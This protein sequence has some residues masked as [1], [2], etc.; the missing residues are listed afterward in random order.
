MLRVVACVARWI[1]AV[2]ALQARVKALVEVGA[3]L[4]EKNHLPLVNLIDL[5]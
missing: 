5:A 2:R 3:W 4:W 1:T